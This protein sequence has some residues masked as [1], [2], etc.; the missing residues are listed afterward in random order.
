MGCRD[1]AYMNVSSPNL[2]SYDFYSTFI[3]EH[4]DVKAWSIKFRDAFQSSIILFG[5]AGASSQ[6]RRV[7]AGAGAAST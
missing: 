3:P 1:V 6:K 4:N 2:V 7:G 5:D